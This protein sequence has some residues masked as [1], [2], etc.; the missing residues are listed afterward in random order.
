[1]KRFIFGMDQKSPSACAR[2][3]RERGIDAVA[4]GNFTPEAAAALDAQGIEMYL[5]CGAYGIKKDSD[6]TA[7]DAFGRPQRWF[8]SG[9]PNDHENASALLD[10]VIERACAIPHLKGI[11]VDGARFASFASVEGADPFFTCFC[12]RCMKEME[13][14]G[15]DAQAIRASVGALMQTRTVRREDEKHL[16][17]WLSFRETCI[18][19]YM[20]QFAGRVHALRSDLLAGAFIFAPSLGVYVG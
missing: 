10:A 5:S 15:L 4:A 12:P 3:L 9:C 18:Q 14:M 19:R 17:A 11:L 20:D 7:Q 8:N 6:R 2:L 1:M 16:K 13:Q